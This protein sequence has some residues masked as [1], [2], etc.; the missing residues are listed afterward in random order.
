MC[1]AGKV[2]E[3]KTVFTVIAAC[4]SLSTAYA[5]LCPPPG[6]TEVESEV[7]RAWSAA[8][9]VVMAEVA[10][11]DEFFSIGDRRVGEAEFVARFYEPRTPPDDAPE[12]DPNLRQ[13]VQWRVLETW[14]G[15]S[16]P[17]ATVETDT[18][19]QCCRSGV[20]VSLGTRRVLYLRDNR[21]N[22]IRA[23]SADS[24]P[25][26]DQARVLARLRHQ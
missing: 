6:F 1:S 16:L 9:T 8:D 21:K 13:V 25:I 11:V 3:V 24:Y 22:S 5:S 12:D 7:R 14:K 2:L 23:C 19:V 4:A 18:P 20:R 17:G 26:A 10:Y 15:S